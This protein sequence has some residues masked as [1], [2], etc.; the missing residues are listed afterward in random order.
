MIISESLHTLHSVP[1][2]SSHNSLWRDL[3]SPSELTPQIR[4]AIHFY[5]F[6]QFFLSLHHWHVYWG[7]GW[8]GAEGSFVAQHQFYRLFHCWLR[9]KKER[10][11]NKG[12]GDVHLKEQHGWLLID[13]LCVG[14]RG[15]AKGGGCILFTVGNLISCHGTTFQVWSVSKCPLLLTIFQWISLLTVSGNSHWEQAKNSQSKIMWMQWV[16]SIGPSS[17][18]HIWPEFKDKLCCI[19]L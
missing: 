1:M 19:A 14:Q 13:Q 6:C 7:D 2:P 12:A 18:T 9:M 16:Y 10:G 11:K 3:T 15:K 17:T 5:C 8:V 4:N